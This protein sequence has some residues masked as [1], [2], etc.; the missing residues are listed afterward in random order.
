MELGQ[1]PTAG[2]EWHRPDD[3]FVPVRAGEIV[4]ALAADAAEF[5]CDPAALHGVADALRDVIEQ[6]AAAFRRELADQYAVFN[7]DRDTQPDRPLAELRTPAAY[8]DIKARLEYLLEKA[9]FAR[10]TEEQVAAAIR[11]AN[12]YGLRIRLCPE[13]IEH[14]AVWVR[15]HGA[16]ERCRRDWRH[17]M[18]GEMHELPV[19]RRLVVVAR[20]KKDPHV[21]IK[22][23]KDIPEIDVEAL[24][25]HAEVAMSWLDRAMVL[26]GGAGAV[27]TT[28]LKISKIALSLAML[29]KLLWVVL[30]GA[31]TLLF[32][33]FMGYRRART[34]RDSQR[35]RHLYFQNLSNNGGAL[36]T[37]I[38]MIAEE[39]AK[40]AVLAYAFCH[41]GKD[42]PRSREEL[43]RRIEGWLT[44]R[45]GAAVRFDVTDAVETV[46]RLGFWR[47]GE[48]FHVQSCGSAEARLREHWRTRSSEYYYSDGVR[49]D[50]AG[51]GSGD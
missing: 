31:G 42:A 50:E 27:G 15:G 6:E 1:D 14:F 26:G 22:V 38:A 7:P 16:L 10:L 48:E 51:V 47:D 37:L 44:H 45:F 3:R 36:Q 2:V 49:A 46:G 13:R 21:I 24:L 18:R 17:P 9:N 11:R 8:A 23:F 41:A 35:T 43:G 34:S 28:A 25:L 33:T 39:E 4:A 20:L 30:F 32:R 5:D 29:S 19:F 40:E 12:S